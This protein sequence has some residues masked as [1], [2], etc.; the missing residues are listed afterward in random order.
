M[1]EPLIH[2]LIPFVVLGFCG[3]GVKKSL[4]L[5]PLAILPD[6]DV[7]L[8]VHR[9]VTH[10]AVVLLLILIP[11]CLFI[12]VKH[13]HY[14]HDSLVGG[15]VVLSHPI[16][17]VFDTYTPLLYP[18]YKKSVFVFCRL[19]TDMSELSDLD[20]LFEIRTVSTSFSLIAPNTEGVVFS[21]LGIAIGLVVLVGVVAKWRWEKGKRR[22]R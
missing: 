5:S 1:P 6:L 15:L 22:R 18:L 9:S 2:F 13:P 14:F 11:I 17:D 21:G 12:R 7:L 3:V 8:H 10:S 4:V 16:L 19:T 20:F